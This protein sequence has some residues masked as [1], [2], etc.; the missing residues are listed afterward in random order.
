[1]QGTPFELVP[2]RIEVMEVNDWE[3]KPEKDM[4]IKQKRNNRCIDEDL[5]L[6]LLS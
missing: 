3:V 6:L 5:I 4:T 2:F 1:M